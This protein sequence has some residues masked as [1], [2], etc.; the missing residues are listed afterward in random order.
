MRACFL[1][2]AAFLVFTNPSHFLRAQAQQSPDAATSADIA[3]QLIVQAHGWFENLAV[4]GK[5]PRVFTGITRDARQ[6]IVELDSLDFD[7][8]KR[9]DFM[10]WLSR[11]FGVIAYAYATRVFRQAE[12]GA[13]PKEAL[14]IYASS[15]GKD[16]ATSFSILRNAAHGPS[17]VVNLLIE[18]PNVFLCLGAEVTRRDNRKNGHE[19]QSSW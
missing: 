18:L 19:S 3:E 7:Q 14:D 15:L 12:S 4:Q 6:F 2:I 8:D 9:R 13:E 5:V 17:R 10:I 16:A 11:K 1:A